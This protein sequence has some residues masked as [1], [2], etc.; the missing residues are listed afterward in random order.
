M[1]APTPVSAYSLRHHGEGGRLPGRPFAL[2]FAGVV[3]WRPLVVTVGLVT[4]VAGG[5]RALRQRPQAA[6][7]LRD[8]EPAR[9]HGGAGDRHRPGPG[10]RVRCSSWPTACSRPPCSWSWA[11]SSIRPGPGTCAACAPG[12]GLAAGERR[13]RRVGRLDGRRAADLRVHRQG[14][15][16]RRPGRRAVLVVGPGPR[17]GGGRIDGHG[18]L[19]PPLRLGRSAGPGPG[20]RAPPPAGRGRAA[21]ARLLA[22]AAL[23]AAAT[24]VLGIAPALVDRW[25]GGAA[26]A[27]D[28][29]VEPV[30]L[31]LWHG[32]NLPLAPVGGGARRRRRP[33]RRPAAAGAGLAAGGRLA[34]RVGG[35]PRGA[36]GRERRGRPGHRGSCRT[37][38][39]PTPAS[40]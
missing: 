13:H 9:V 18:R 28:P 27:L 34:Q 11:S 26:R 4:M 39:P 36:A 16:L 23:L 31:A 40:S 37:A 32:L 17:P 24:V 3:V 10:G 20:I 15:G 8:R 1:V 22:P 35:L 19:Q 5:L 14:G 38:C 2:A 21:R 12:G 30:H 33:V 29:A 7:G 25:A 6:A